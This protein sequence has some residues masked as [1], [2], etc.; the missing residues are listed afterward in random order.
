MIDCLLISVLAL[1][2]PVTMLRND[3]PNGIS[4]PPQVIDTSRLT[5]RNTAEIERLTPHTNNNIVMLNANS[6]Q[7]WHRQCVREHL[8]PQQNF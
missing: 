2:F 5:R 4:L 6:A 3:A 8:F 7:H 1:L